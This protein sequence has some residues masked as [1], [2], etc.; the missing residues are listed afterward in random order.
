MDLLPRWLLSVG[1]DVAAAVVAQRLTLCTLGDRL[2]PVVL[3]MLV[4]TLCSHTWS[5]GLLI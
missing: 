4:N 1:T 3:G 2:G 5:L